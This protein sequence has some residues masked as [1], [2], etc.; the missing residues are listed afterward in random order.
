MLL[1][2]G[3]LLT[4]AGINL[5]SAEAQEALIKSAYRTAGLETDETGYFEAHGTGQAPERPV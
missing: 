1:G 3:T 2:F 5:P 4:P